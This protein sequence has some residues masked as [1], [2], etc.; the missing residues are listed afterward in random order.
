MHDMLS[1]L[2]TYGY[3][4]LFIYSLGGGMV[5][6]IAASVLSYMGKMDLAVSMAIA[7]SANV[8]G[9]NLLFYL[10]RNQKEVMH[11]YLKKHRRKLALAHIQM[12]RY[13]SWI[14][15]LQK[16]IYGIK[17]LIPIAIGLTKYDLRK[18]TILN[19]VSAVV[20]TLTVGFVSYF[21]GN[22]LMK[23]Y[24]FLMTK[25]YIAIIIVLGLIA[26]IWIYLSVA[27]KK[28]KSL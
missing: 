5:A 16:F 12:K 28:K 9:D 2:A 21:F 8:I 13:G 27:T 4:A 24:E 25:P 7:F 17:T 20:W 19:I 3:I 22:A 23:A 10:A 18:F 26:I 15:L 14:I 11:P 6:L 1:N